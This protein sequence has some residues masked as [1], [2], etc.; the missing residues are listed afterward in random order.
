MLTGFVFLSILFN[1]V[2]IYYF[3]TAQYSREYYMIYKFWELSL[4]MGP[5]IT[6]I[7]PALWNSAIIMRQNFITFIYDILEASG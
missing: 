3:C 1:P 7:F 6:F 4:F 5:A 2:T